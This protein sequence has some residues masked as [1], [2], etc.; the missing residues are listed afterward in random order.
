MFG[1]ERLQRGFRSDGIRVP[2][3]IL[4]SGLR[5][6]GDKPVVIVRLQLAGDLIAPKD[7]MAQA[8][9]GFIAAGPFTSQQ[10]QKERERS[11]YEQL[12]DIVGTLG[13]SMLGMTIGCAR[14]HDHKFDPIGRHD[15]Y[16]LVSNFAETGFQDYDWD[17]DPVG[18][19]A[20]L[21]AFNAKHKTV[22]R[23]SRCVRK[24]TLP[25]RLAEWE[26]T[27]S[28][29][30]AAENSASGNTLARSLTVPIR[31]RSTRSLPRNKVDLAKPVGKL[32]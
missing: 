21:E 32:K 14:C 7:Y 6:I 28:N 15:Y 24:D 1:V 26:A 19:K 13:T 3:V 31:N 25:L 29:A 9:T 18:T 22:L 8:A 23:R 12:D 27:K 20:A 4:E 11:R 5:E 17:P 10:T 30:P 16:R 2:V